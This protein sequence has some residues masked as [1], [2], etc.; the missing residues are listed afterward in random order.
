MPGAARKRGT[1][2]LDLYR[3]PNIPRNPLRRRVFST[4]GRGPAFADF[5]GHWLIVVALLR[6]K[7]T[8]ER[9]DHTRERLADIANLK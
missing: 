6:A 7:S 8:T 9:G 5:E 3:V 2:Q 1:S 4:R